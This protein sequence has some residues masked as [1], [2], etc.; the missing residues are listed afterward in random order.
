MK[1]SRLQQY[2]KR[3]FFAGAFQESLQKKLKHLLFRR[4]FVDYK[5][6]IAEQKS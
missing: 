4:L 2:E 6:R 1:P 3:K 5:E